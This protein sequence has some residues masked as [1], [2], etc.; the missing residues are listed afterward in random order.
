MKVVV[1]GKEL[2][3][4]NL[5]Y[6]SQVRLKCEC[7]VPSNVDDKWQI[8]IEDHFQFKNTAKTYSIVSVKDQAPVQATHLL[9]AARKTQALA[10]RA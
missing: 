6:T 10:K 8:N 3:D 2:A 4:T 1:A 9:A 7:D 5:T